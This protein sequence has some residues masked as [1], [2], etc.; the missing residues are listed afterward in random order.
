MED[1][2]KQLPSLPFEVIIS[3]SNPTAEKLLKSMSRDLLFEDTYFG[4]IK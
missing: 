4:D 2:E 3:D 1:D